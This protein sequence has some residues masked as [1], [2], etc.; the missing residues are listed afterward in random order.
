MGVPF[1]VHLKNR[2]EVGEGVSKRLAANSEGIKINF[3]VKFSAP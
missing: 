1:F 2:N 3:D